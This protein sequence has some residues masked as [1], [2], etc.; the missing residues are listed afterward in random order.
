LMFREMLELQSNIHRPTWPTGCTRKESS[1][2]SMIRR[3]P[4]IGMSKKNDTRHQTLVA[5]TRI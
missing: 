2:I 5:D 4:R 3:G 1:M